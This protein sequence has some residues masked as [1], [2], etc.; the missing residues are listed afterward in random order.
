MIHRLLSVWVFIAAFALPAG[1]QTVEL[2]TRTFWVGERPRTMDGDTPFIALREIDWIEA[3]LGTDPVL[4]DAVVHIELAHMSVAETVAF[5]YPGEVLLGP[6]RLP[7]Q[8]HLPDYRIY[9]PE[10]ATGKSF[11][12]LP[13]DPDAGFRVGCGE[14]NDVRHMS[15]CVINATYSPDDH[16]R[17]KARLYFPPDPADAPTYFRDVVERMR[18]V[19]HCLDVTD[20]PV[21]VLAVR[22]ELTGCLLKPIS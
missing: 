22:P 9:G 2:S 7:T 6:D 15:V 17:L 8:F 1:A 18:E 20:D 19:A 13:T 12:Y 16:I 3:V 21:E 4:R 11:T 10:I 5:P 14:R